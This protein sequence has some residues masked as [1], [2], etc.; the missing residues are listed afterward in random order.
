MRV[1]LPA[2]HLQHDVDTAIAL[3][4]NVLEKPESYPFI[5]EPIANESWVEQVG[6]VLGLLVP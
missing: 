5:L 2:L 3:C 1:L 6:L 4:A